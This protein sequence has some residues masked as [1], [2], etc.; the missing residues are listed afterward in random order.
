MGLGRLNPGCQ[1]ANPCKACEGVP[2]CQARKA[3]ITFSGLTDCVASLNG[4]Y[5]LTFKTNAQE[6]NCC[7]ISEFAA[8]YSANFF[9]PSNCIQASSLSASCI[10]YTG[11]GGQASCGGNAGGVPVLGGYTIRYNPRTSNGYGACSG[12]PWT[13]LSIEWFFLCFA[14]NFSGFVNACGFGRPEGFCSPESM[15]TSGFRWFTGQA[16]EEGDFGLGS[17]FGMS[18]ISNRPSAS[19]VLEL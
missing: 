12:V 8:D 9:D 17:P 18:Q 11:P 16:C 14:C 3:R 19:I 4:D 15:H 7:F 1:Q 6:G 2:C 10:G 13:S 5:T